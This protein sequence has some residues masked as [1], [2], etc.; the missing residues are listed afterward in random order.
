V[1]E[2]HDHYTAAGK[3]EEYAKTFA[4]FQPAL[5]GTYADISVIIVPFASGVEQALEAP[6]TEILLV[7]LQ[8][9]KSES[10]LES[11]FE[12]MAR[13]GQLIGQHWGPVRERENRFAFIVGWKSVK[14]NEFFPFSYQVIWLTRQRFH[15][16]ITDLF[17]LKHSQTWLLKERAR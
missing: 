6:V 13:T 12:S 11:L 2:S 5:E 3:E 14:V 4:T 17:E 7:S 10:D 15:S 9:G 8:Q 1:W 16:I